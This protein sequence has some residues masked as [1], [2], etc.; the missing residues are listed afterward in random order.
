VFGRNIEKTKTDA[1]SVTQDYD[2]REEDALSHRDEVITAHKRTSSIPGLL[3]W[4]LVFLACVSSFLSTTVFAQTGG[5]TASDQAA[6]V[7]EGAAVGI[8]LAVT[9]DPDGG[10]LTYTITSQPSNGTLSGVEPNLTYTH[11]GSLQSGKSL[12]RIPT[13]QYY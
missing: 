8:T 13:Q 5:P 3:S 11:N 10:E 7:D 2:P 1:N 4:S 9:P 12:V 6:S